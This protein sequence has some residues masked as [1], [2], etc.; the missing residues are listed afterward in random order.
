MPSLLGP[1]EARLHISGAIF[2]WKTNK[3]QSVGQNK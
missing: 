1:P 2:L 3:A